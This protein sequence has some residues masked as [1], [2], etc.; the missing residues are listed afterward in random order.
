MMKKRKTIFSVLEKK[1][2]LKIKVFMIKKFDTNQISYNQLIDL[3]GNAKN[4]E[5]GKAN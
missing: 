5:L 4:R 2:K 1:N 3:E